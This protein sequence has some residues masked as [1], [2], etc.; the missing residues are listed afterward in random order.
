VVSYRGNQPPVRAARCPGDC[1]QPIRAG[2]FHRAIPVTGTPPKQREGVVRARHRRPS[3]TAPVA[4]SRQ[5]LLRPAGDC[6][7]VRV[8][9]GPGRVTAA[10]VGRWHQ[11]RQI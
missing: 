5:G 10:R 11:T 8:T 1:H 2:S 7:Q 4:P 6:G 9:A 3:A